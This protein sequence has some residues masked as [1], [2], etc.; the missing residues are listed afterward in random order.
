MTYGFLAIVR[1]VAD[2]MQRCE[3]T[4][5]ERTPIDVE[6]A[7]RQHAG[8][9]EALAGLGCTIHELPA[10]HDLP[11]SVFV[12]DTAVVLDEVAVVTRPGAASRRAEVDAM[13]GAL[14]RW[15]HCVRVE[16]PGTLDGGDVLVVDRTLY[17]GRTPRSNAAGIAALA[18]AVAPHGHRVV[19]V[20]VRGC[21]HLKS[22]VTRVAP[23]ALLVNPDWVDPGTWPGL[24]RIDVDPGE[25]HAANA[26]ACGGRVLSPSSFPGTHERLA[27][28]GLEVVTVDASEVQRAEGGVTCCS[29][30]LRCGQAGFQQ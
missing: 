7:R 15:R 25:P 24:R 8:Y 17:V 5:L 16:A 2:A 11:D 3:L 12:E 30:I 6:R 4:H 1:P 23:D 9:V 20:D 29:V 18:A 27:R 14:A 13:A 26:L 19:P 10:A 22:A 28:A 21:L